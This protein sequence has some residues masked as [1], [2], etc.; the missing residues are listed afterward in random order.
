[1]FHGVRVVPGVAAVSITT[2]ARL[3]VGSASLAATGTADRPVLAERWRAVRRGALV[4][5]L[6]A[7]AIG[8]CTED[9]T[10]TQSESITLNVRGDNQRGFANERLPHA[11]Q[12]EVKDGQGRP[13]Q[14]AEV[15]FAPDAGSGSVERASAI[16]DLM[17][18]A[19]TIW[20]LGAQEEREQRVHIRVV[21]PSA[22]AETV[23]EALVLRNDE[24]DIVVV[25][26]AIGSLRGVV[27]VSD[28]DNR[29]EIVYHRSTRDTLVYLLP[30]DYPTDI[31]VFSQLNRPL[32]TTA[33]WTAGVDTIHVFLEPPVRLGVDVRIYDGIFE[34]RRAV[35]EDRLAHTEMLWRS[36]G[37][38]VTIGDVTWA[39]A[40]GVAPLNISSSGVCSQVSPGGAVR[41]HVVRSID[42]SWYTGWG[43]LSG[44]VFLG[45]GADA[46]VNLL[47]HEIGHTFTL[48]HTL[49]G[50]M[51]PNPRSGAV[52]DGEIFRAHFDDLSVLNTIAAG[53]PAPVRRN[54]R[55]DHGSQCL[56]VLY[57]LP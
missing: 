29:L 42:N 32:R 50:L 23:A 46:Y 11:I 1:M 6:A 34:E 44:D 49:A 18:R 45:A 2:L 47:A 48:S 9:P 43:C 17:G 52:T 3:R 40:T 31:V 14:G 54:C 57:E 35:W 12:V 56:P 41:V 15:S 22:E 55:I 36:I 26:G 5:A 38:G 8:G 51:N 7:L 20:V 16:T 4:A 24:A 25:H 13:V 37:M 28:I 21:T 30:M 53:Q 19:A 39:D 33:T 10:G 27:L